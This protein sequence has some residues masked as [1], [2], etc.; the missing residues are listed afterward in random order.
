MSAFGF[1]QCQRALIAI[2]DTALSKK[3]SIKFLRRPEA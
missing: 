3:R 2:P 1:A